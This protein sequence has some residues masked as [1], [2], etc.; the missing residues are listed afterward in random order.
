MRSRRPSR[1]DAATQ[2]A[3]AGRR[4]ATL[5]PVSAHEI[6]HL[7]HQY[8]CLLIFVAVGLQALGAP[9]P[10]TTALIAGALYAATTRGFPIAGVIAAGA[11]GALVGTLG[12]FALG[13]WGGERLSLRIGAGLRQSPERVMRMRSEFA[14]HGRG[15]LFFGRFIT[16]VRN[17]I[18]LVAGASGMPVKRFLPIT[19]A[20]VA[21]WAVGN[22]LG[23]YWFGHTLAG[24]STWVQVAMVCAGVVWMVFSLSLLR[25]RVFRR[26]S[27]SSAA[28]LS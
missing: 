3:T 21:V 17:V 4:Y 23:Y 10:G 11:S 26:L 1:A 15:W 28:E 24:A 19:A 5:I 18:G 22:G 16:G 25:R 20:A 6:G 14:V 8:G 7:V 27:G 12:G 13:R 2:A 9:L